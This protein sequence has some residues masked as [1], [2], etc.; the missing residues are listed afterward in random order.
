M[1]GV[2]PVINSTALMAVFSGGHAEV[3]PALLMQAHLIGGRWHNVF[4]RVLVGNH[5]DKPLQGAVATTGAG[6]EFVVRF[7]LCN[8]WWRGFKLD[9]YGFINC[10]E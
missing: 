5:V 6:S 9:Q 3:E 7:C 4:S 10:V 8:Y 1:I 2:H